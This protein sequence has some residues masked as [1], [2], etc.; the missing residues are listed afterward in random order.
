M[1]LRRPNPIAGDG[2]VNREHLI[3]PIVNDAQCGT[4]MSY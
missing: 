1:T 3:E 4:P 2:V